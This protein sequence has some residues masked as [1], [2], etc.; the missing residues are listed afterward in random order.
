MSGL[1]LPVGTAKPSGAC[2]KSTSEFG[3]ILFSAMSSAKPSRDN[4][5]TSAVTP[6][7]SC[8][9][10]VFGPEPCE[11]PDLVM[12]VIPVIFSKEGSIWL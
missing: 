5:T 9:L 7:A 8:A 10:I 2:A 4:M 1:A 3:T 11:A 12:T 6:V